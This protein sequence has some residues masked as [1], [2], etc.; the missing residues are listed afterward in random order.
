MIKAL[1]ITASIAFAIGAIG[2][3]ILQKMET[4]PIAAQSPE[5]K[6]NDEAIAASIPQKSNRGDLLLKLSLCANR[7]LDKA[8]VDSL[9]D[10][11]LNDLTFDVCKR[12][13]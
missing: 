7:K 3:Y 8:F 9:N 2:G 11:Q 4:T 13:S 12:N 10:K 1:C 5:P 6:K